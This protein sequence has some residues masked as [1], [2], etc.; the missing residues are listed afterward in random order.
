[1]ILSIFVFMAEFETRELKKLQT[2]ICCG[3]KKKFEKH[4]QD[5]GM[6]DAPLLKYIISEYYAKVNTDYNK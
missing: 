4:K 2:T 6:L 1:M 3:I 5:T